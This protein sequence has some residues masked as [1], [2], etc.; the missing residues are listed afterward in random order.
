MGHIGELFIPFVH[1]AAHINPHSVQFASN[2]RHSNRWTS[3]DQ[4]HILW[5]VVVAVQNLLDLISAQSHLAQIV[6]LLIYNIGV[7]G[8]G[9][10]VDHRSS[11][12]RQEQNPGHLGGLGARQ[13]LRIVPVDER[14]R[15]G[16]L[17]R[18]PVG[19]GR[20]WGGQR[21]VKAVFGQKLN[22]TKLR[23]VRVH[24]LIDDVN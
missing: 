23:A 17:T 12:V 1:M 3:V 19:L 13:Q 20:L 10:G 22:Q 4:L 14:R 11:F 2:G 24:L 6:L 15:L 9:T 7:L 18:G 16:W 5:L 8:L 21:L